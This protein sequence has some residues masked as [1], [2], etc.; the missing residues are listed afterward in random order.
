MKEIVLVYSNQLPACQ[1]LIRDNAFVSCIEEIRQKIDVKSILINDE[2]SRKGLLNS[3]Q[4]KIPILLI[5]TGNEF[6]EI[7]GV[8]FIVKYVQDLANSL[9]KNINNIDDEYSEIQ[10][11]SDSVEDTKIFQSLKIQPLDSKFEDKLNHIPIIFFRNIFYIECNYLSNV[12]KKDYDLI[13]VNDSCE[14][15]VHFEDDNLKIINKRNATYKYLDTVFSDITVD[16]KILVVSLDKKLAEWV[17][18][19]YID[20]YLKKQ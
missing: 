11:T 6:Q 9:N 15:N 19:Y 5:D 17:K 18:R 20:K 2:F 7:K 8:S 14:K 12:D 16:N 10:D 3:K 1:K 4:T 13:L